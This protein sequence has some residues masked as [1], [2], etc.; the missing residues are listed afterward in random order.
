MTGEELKQHIYELS[1]ALD[2]HSAGKDY[3]ALRRTHYN[4]IEWLQKNGLTEEYYGV[5]FAH[6]KVGRYKEQ[7]QGHW[8]HDGSHWENRWICTACRHKLF[9]EQTRFCPN[10]GA[11]MKGD[12]ESEV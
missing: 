2:T 11:K 3:I 1:Y 4:N 10:C 8:M 6:I 9:G 12:E 5:L 7:K